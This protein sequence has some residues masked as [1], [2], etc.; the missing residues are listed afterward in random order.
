[1]IPLMMQKDYAPKGWR[2]S[3]CRVCMPL[4]LYELGAV[5]WLCAAGHVRHYSSLQRAR[6]TLATRPVCMS[7]LPY[8]NLPLQRC[9]TPRHAPHHTTQY[10][11]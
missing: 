4:R 1:M 3:Q 5:V 11:L 10:A 6:S 8:L 9:I 2:K 7:R